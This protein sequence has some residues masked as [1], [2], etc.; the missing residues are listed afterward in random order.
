VFDIRISDHPPSTQLVLRRQG[1][2]TVLPPLWLRARSPEASQRDPAT[3]QRLF[4]PHLLPDNLTLTS[5]SW[6]DDRLQLA[7]SDGFTGAF[8]AAGVP[9]G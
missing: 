9:L 5:A 8:D 1:T 7:F 3:G 4:N 6:Q 2:D